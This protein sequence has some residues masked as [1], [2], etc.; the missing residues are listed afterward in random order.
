MKISIVQVPYPQYGEAEKVLQWQI[1][2][3]NN[4]ERNSTEMI[5]FPENANCT[6]Y[7][8]KENMLELICNKGAEFVETMRE[9]AKRINCTIVSRAY[10]A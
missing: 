1:D 3:L 2:L 10:D 8:D 4:W 5:I 7:I 9:S 6:G